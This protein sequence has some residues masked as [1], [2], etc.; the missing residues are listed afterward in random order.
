MV[1]H[2][3]TKCETFYVKMDGFLWATVDSIR[4]QQNISNAPKQTGVHSRSTIGVVSV[5]FS[6]AVKLTADSFKVV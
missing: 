2:N 1:H 5:S 6:K 3:Q 4:K